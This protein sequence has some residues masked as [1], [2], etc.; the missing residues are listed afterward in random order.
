MYDPTS[1]PFTEAD[2]ESFIDGIDPA[3]FDRVTSAF[4]EESIGVPE[5]RDGLGNFAA[6]LKASAQLALSKSGDMILPLAVLGRPDGR[7]YFVADDDESYKMWALRLAREAAA[8]QATT[9]GVY[10]LTPAAVGDREDVVVI[11]MCL[12]M[13]GGYDDGLVLALEVDADRTIVT[14]HVSGR[15]QLPEFWLPVLDY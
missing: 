1:T 8:W 14:Q 12:M 13:R 5:T 6:S 2:I 7:R 9:F 3:H 15:D 11:M 10:Y 4:R